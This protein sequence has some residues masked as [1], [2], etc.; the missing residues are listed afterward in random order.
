MR[1]PGRDAPPRTARRTRPRLRPGPRAPRFACGRRRPPP[2]GA[3]LRRS[4]GRRLTALAGSGAAARSFFGGVEHVVRLG[5]GFYPAYHW[6]PRF[7]KRL[8]GQEPDLD[9]EIVAGAARGPL[10][11]LDEGGIDLA[12]VALCQCNLVMLF[13]LYH[14]A[15]V[16]HRDDTPVYV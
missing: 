16:G 8:R 6:L 1:S 3:G 15:V 7:L 4:A 2:A 11:M 13:S 9:V 12:V 14:S 10:D 5:I